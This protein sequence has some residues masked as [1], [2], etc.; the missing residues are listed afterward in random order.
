MRAVA[1]AETTKRLL[2]ELA[3]NQVGIVLSSEDTKAVARQFIETVLQDEQLQAQVVRSVQ[4][5][6]QPQKK[7]PRNVTEV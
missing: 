3:A 1:T 4:P 2:T 5:E 6:K 7:R